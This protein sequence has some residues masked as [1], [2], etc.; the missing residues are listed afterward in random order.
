MII[1][2]FHSTHE[3]LK[4]EKILKINSI[5]FE[6][7]PTP[8]EYSSDC[9]MALRTDKNNTDSINTLKE[10]CGMDIRIVED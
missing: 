8:R 9:G 1:L 3:V 4:F 7:I 10:E 6:V 2:I 5:S